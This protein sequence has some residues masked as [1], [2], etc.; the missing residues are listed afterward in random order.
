MAFNF[1]LI[2]HVITTER[3]KIRKKLEFENKIRRPDAIVRRVS[4]IRCTSVDFGILFLSQSITFFFPMLKHPG[5][6]SSDK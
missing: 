6:I 5:L 1:N 4:D 3:R 2:L